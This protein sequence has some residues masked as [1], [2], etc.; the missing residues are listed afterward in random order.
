M[1]MF[2][3]L[4]NLDEAVKVHETF[5][6]P[7]RFLVQESVRHGGPGVDL[8]LLDRDIEFGRGVS[9]DEFGLFQAHQIREH[10]AGDVDQVTHRLGADFQTGS[11]AELLQIVEARLPAR[12]KNMVA[13]AIA[14]A[15]IAYFID[16]IENPALAENRVHHEG[17][18][19][20]SDGQA[21]RTDRL[22]DVV[23]RLPPAATV[24]VLH[25]HGGISRNMLL[26]KR[27]K[28]FGPHAPDAAGRAALQDGNGFPLEER[29]LRK[30]DAA[31]EETEQKRDKRNLE[32]QHRLGSGAPHMH[33]RNENSRFDLL[34]FVILPLNRHD[35]TPRVTPLTNRVNDTT[36]LC[37]SNGRLR[38][39][40]STQ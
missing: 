26:Q 2:P 7:L 38:G 36:L 33:P 13:A 18:R 32:K 4:R 39:F 22:I 17:R 11:R 14:G 35:L 28:S 10:S 8:A 20:T 37:R 9:G 25:H 24:H 12:E 34:S 27:N 40:L 23:C 6:D 5:I 16:V 21:V 29:S 31:Y 19:H 30:S 3:S 15:Q 1:G